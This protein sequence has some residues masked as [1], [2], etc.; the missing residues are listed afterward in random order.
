MPRLGNYQNG[1]IYSIRS[2]QTDEIYIGSTTQS[3]S[4]RMA[5]HR[6]NYKKYLN[7]KNNYFTSFKILEFDDAYIELIEEFP[8]VSKMHLEKREGEVIRKMENCVNRRIAGRTR[9]EYKQDNKEHFKE[10]AK[11][12][13]KQYYEANKEQIKEHQKQYYEANKEQINE[14]RGVKIT[15]ECGSTFTR[16]QKLRHERTQ[17]HK[18]YL[19]N[20]SIV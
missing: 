7:G 15:C 5:E 14:H 10:Y 16:A 17:K 4:V 6:R 12:Y 18:N 19:L 9:K 11:Q 8:C 2:H 1:K 3:L 13:N 20:N